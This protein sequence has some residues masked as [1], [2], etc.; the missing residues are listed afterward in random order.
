MRPP[1][2][3]RLAWL[4]RA[5]ATQ[6]LR[7][8][9]LER[10]R[11]RGRCLTRP[12]TTS[13]STCRSTRNRSDPAASRSGFPRTRSFWSWH[14][15]CSLTGRHV[16]TGRN[17]HLHLNG[18]SFAK[19]S[20]QRGLAGDSRRARR[21]AFKLVAARGRLHSHLDHQH[22]CRGASHTLERLPVSFE[23]PFP[24]AGP[25]ARQRCPWPNAV[26]SF[27]LVGRC[28]SRHGRTS[29]PN[30]GHS[31]ARAEGLWGSGSGSW[32]SWTA[33]SSARG[34]PP[35]SPCRL[36]PV[37]VSVLLPESRSHAQDF[38]QH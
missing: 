29:P 20:R 19:D 33:P 16:F 32:T 35:R 1:W 6:A 21:V 13:P 14:D 25:H 8:A 24:I 3:P 22:C 12:R 38:R 34:W 30:W 9:L 27:P 2:P 37:A 15:A 4:S 5:D 28:P 17:Q 11:P 31:V 10:T 18:V 26:R 23:I 36:M 7:L